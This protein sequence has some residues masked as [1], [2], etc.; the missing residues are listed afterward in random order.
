[1]S[2]AEVQYR[3]EK[4]AIRWPRKHFLERTEWAN[5]GARFRKDA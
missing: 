1:M 4:A 2:A 5:I 3:G